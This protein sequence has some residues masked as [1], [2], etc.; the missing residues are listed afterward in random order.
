MFKIEIAIEPVSEKVRNI[1]KIREK[2]QISTTDATK[3]YDSLKTKSDPLNKE[4]IDKLVE[5]GW[6][7]ISTNLEEIEK[8]KKEQ[9]NKFSK[10]AHYWYN[11]LSDSEKEYVAYFQR[12]MLPTAQHTKQ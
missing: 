4:T 5:I 10:E 7:I 2:L 8:E 6:Q 11:K 9:M 1:V 3:L 12:M